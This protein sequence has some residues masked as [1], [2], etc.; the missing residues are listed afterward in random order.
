MRRTL[1]SFVAFGLSICAIPALAVE[2]R[3]LSSWD[4]SYLPRAEL[5]EKFLKSVENT[6]KG[7]IKFRI[8]G[9]ET[10]PPFEQLQPTGSN[11]FQILFTHGAYHFGT[12][13]YLVA[14][15]GLTGDLGKWREA[16]IREQVD[17][18]YQKFGVK[19]LALPSVPEGSAYNIILKA[20]VTASGDLQGRKIR[21][22]Q[23][24]AGVLAMLGASPVNL[25]P[26]EIYPSLEKSVVDGAAWPVIGPLGYKWY[27]VA[28]HV[29]RPSFGV[30]VQ[31]IFVNLTAW[32][33]LTD[34]QRK[35]LEDEARKIEDTWFAE[36]PRLAKAEQDGLVARGA[37]ITEMGAAQKEKL[38]SSWTAGVIEFTLPRN[39]KDIGELRDFAKSKGLLR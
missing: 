6:S 25:P 4:Q 22:T 28:K 15:E 8:S 24:Y 38:A 7:D 32:N 3:A 17:R 20:P 1:A 31:P 30:V 16:G 35:I 33:S 23:S 13:P 9:P 26:A 11:V 2:L 10:V 27:E 21:A 39:P 19:I 34:S 37:Q 29:L 12:T 36:W 5:F 14:L 18:H